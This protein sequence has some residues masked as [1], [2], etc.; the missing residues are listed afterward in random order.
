[1]RDGFLTCSPAVGGYLMIKFY[2]MLRPLIFTNRRSHRGWLFGTRRRE[3]AQMLH[4]LSAEETDA[5]TRTRRAERAKALT[6]QV[7]HVL[8]RCL[9]AS[10]AGRARTMEGSLT[11]GPS[12]TLARHNG[13]RSNL[14]LY[15]LFKDDVKRNRPEGCAPPRCESLSPRLYGRADY[16]G[17]PD[18]LVASGTL[19]E[20]GTPG[21]AGE[22]A[23]ARSKGLMSEWSRASAPSRTVGIRGASG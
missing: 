5:S 1:M 12:Q 4:T 21:D 14:G 23:S 20:C 22:S 9:A 19:E 10:R 18:N 15:L 3:L 11:D 2:S 13:N 8:S 6:A 17:T 7:D 16:A